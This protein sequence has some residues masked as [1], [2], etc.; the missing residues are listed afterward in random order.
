MSAANTASRSPRAA[1]RSWRARSGTSAPRVQ[2]NGSQTTADFALDKDVLELEG[3]TVT[4]QATTVDKRN[5]ST[6]VASV[7]A[8]ELHDGARQVGRRQPRRQGRRRGD[9]REQ[10][11]AGRRHADPDPRRH[12]DSRPGRSAVRRGRHHRLQRLDPRRARVDLSLERFDDVEPGPGGQPA[13]RPE[14][15][16]RREHRS[17]EVG[18]GHGHLRLARNERRRRHHDEERARRD[19]RASTSRSVWASSSRSSCSTRGSSRATTPGAT[20]R[21]SVRSPACRLHRPGELHAGLSATTTGRASSTAT[22]R[23]RIETVLSTSGGSTNTRFFGSLNDRQN[24]GV[25]HNTGARR[26]SGRV[27]LDQTIGDK[28]TR[29]RRRRRHAQLRA[30]RPRQQRQ[31]RHQ[32]DLYLRL[33]AGDL[34]SPEDRSRHRPPGV[35]CG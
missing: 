14:S 7:S 21:G 20:T 23:R 34:R 2:I 30:G 29:E 1:R 35:R 6:A 8:E 16:R 26:T 32:P 33:R 9:L 13:C 28:L 5:A 27:N 17:A 19:Q 4:G 3:V 18:G 25:E 15:Q 31:R 10:R 12:V 22:R 24:K 11:R